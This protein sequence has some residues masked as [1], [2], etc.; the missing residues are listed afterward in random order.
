MEGNVTRIGDKRTHEVME[1][2][3]NSKTLLF[4]AQQWELLYNTQVVNDLDKLA[5]T[6]VRLHKDNIFT[7]NDIL[8]IK[9]LKQYFQ[10]RLRL[11]LLGMLARS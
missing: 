2:T 9:N 10:V 8:G 11:P 1:A 6:N 3:S 4:A 5:A 7:R